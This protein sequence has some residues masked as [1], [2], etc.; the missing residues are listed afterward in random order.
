MEQE[1]VTHLEGLGIPVLDPLDGGH[2]TYI[3][4][5]VIEFSGAVGESDWELLFPCIR[6]AG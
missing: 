5:K 1:I 2:V 4:G 3:M 6:L